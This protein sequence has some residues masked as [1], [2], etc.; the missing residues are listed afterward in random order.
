MHHR[1]VSVLLA[2]PTRYHNCPKQ[3]KFI[4]NLLEQ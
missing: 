1:Y 2:D 3:A 4:V